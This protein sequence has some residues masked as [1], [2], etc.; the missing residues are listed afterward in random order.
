MASFISVELSENIIN[1]KSAFLSV[2]HVL[3]PSGLFVITIGDTLGF[4]FELLR[5]LFDLH[6]LGFS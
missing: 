1:V 2:S 3:K 6:L 5:H 4:F